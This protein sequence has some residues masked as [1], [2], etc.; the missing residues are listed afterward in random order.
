MNASEMI[1]VRRVADKKYTVTADGKTR[2]GYVSPKDC[3][4]FVGTCQ[5][6]GLFPGHK[7]F[8]EDNYGCLN[9]LEPTYEN[10]CLCP[11]VCR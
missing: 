7:L 1:I 5:A 4:E 9:P 2:H 10:P 6:H 8:I 11:A 3:A